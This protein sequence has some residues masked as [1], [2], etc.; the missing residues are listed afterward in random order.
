MR[1]RDA[2]K[3]V[4]T[5]AEQ[6][7]V[8]V[9]EEK[10]AVGGGATGASEVAEPTGVRAKAP[11]NSKTQGDPMQKIQDP[12]NPGVEDTDPENN[13]KAEGN[14]AGNLATLKTKMGEHFDAMFD[15]EELS[16]QFKEKAST[17]FEMAVNYRINEITE[18]LESLYEEKL[19]E[20]VAE[21]EESYTL[22][23]EDLTNK[24]DQYLNYAVEEWVKQN[25]VAIETSL[26]SEITED[27]I[28]GLKSLFA[29]HYIEVPEEKVSVVEELAARVEELETKLNEAVNENIELK[30]SLNEM[31]SEEIFNEISE[32][33]TLS[34]VEKFK[35]LAEG[36]DFDDVENFKNKLLIV[37]ENYFPSTGVKKTA[38]LLEESFDGE[39]P[40]AVASGAMSKYVRA[41]S[42]TTIR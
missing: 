17:I 34:Q 6:Q 30:N 26:R 12:N 23:L 9:I 13:T 42:R 36:V 24:V 35:K 38:N 25:E 10:V 5:E 39:E 3:N 41:I 31:S 29:E 7:E 1:L 21:L 14:A 40:A 20:K 16:E 27:F 28:H 22:Q 18:E 37:K 2:I 8:E 4:L 19:N 11:G 15:G 32:G 33:L